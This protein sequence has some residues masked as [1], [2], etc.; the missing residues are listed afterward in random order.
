M[1]YNLSILI[2][3]LSIIAQS[4]VK[5]HVEINLDSLE[6]YSEFKMLDQALKNQ[7]VV[8]TGENHNYRMQNLPF[9]FKF[10]RYLHEQHDFDTYILEFGKGVEWLVQKYIYEDDSIAH[11]VIKRTYYKEQT[12]L[13]ERIKE[14]YDEQKLT[15]P[16]KV[17]GIDIDRNWGS[18]L[19]ALE[20]IPPKEN[21][22]DSLRLVLESV[23]AV[24]DLYYNN[25]DVRFGFDQQNTSM[26]KGFDYYNG[27]NNYTGS[28]IKSIEIL[29]D[30]YEQKIDGFKAFL[31][32]SF[33]AYDRIMKGLRKGLVWTSYET[34]GVVQ[35]KL[36]REQHIYENMMEFMETKPEAKV[37]G[38]FG[39]CHTGGDTLKIDDCYCTSFRSFIQRLEESEEIDL[40][41]KVFAMPILYADVKNYL[42]VSN[43]RNY[44]GAPGAGFKDQEIVKWY[45]SL[46][47]GNSTG[48]Q[49]LELDHLNDTSAGDIY[50]G[51]GDYGVD[52]DFILI[53]F[54]T[55]Y[56]SDVQ[57]SKN[58]PKHKRDYYSYFHFDGA[59]T[60]QETNFKQLN[61]VMS[62][63]GLEEYDPF[64]FGYSA[65]FLGFEGIGVYA[66]IGGTWWKQET[67]SND[68]I[69]LDLSGIN[70]TGQIGGTL[71]D[72]KNFQLA[73]YYTYGWSRLKLVE[74]LVQPVA[75]LNPQS[76]LETAPDQQNKYL[77]P[78]LLIGGG[79]DARVQL[80][81]FSI[82]LKGGYN[83]DISNK[84][85][86]STSG[87]II[88]T[89]HRHYFV[90]AG[91]S[92]YFGEKY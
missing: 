13:F 63:F 14:Y 1:K 17:I 70:I 21:I 9:S 82:F 66:G 44:N 64:V 41:Q 47:A 89:T 22:P 31:G 74:K 92:L 48:F 37:F 34:D 28:K 87:D 43:Y 11:E 58:G 10:F 65:S 20:M 81:P 75:G 2:M 68:S 40:K 57:L 27:N 18:T 32:N 26:I 54:L 56:G 59:Y 46:M 30:Q 77:N 6:D 71:L 25:Y 78:A 50:S 73:L 36:Y 15:N 69:S 60:L 90:S 52:Y 51:R 24:K 39:R 16:F 8:M 85:W 76:I 7:Q 86:K 49:L 23:S 80:F 83:F 38:Q 72:H 53:D 88:K 35:H 61:T 33:D 79:F 12:E 91:V 84:K 19:N 3:L 4:Q 5:Q 45:Q 42:G 67:R 29:V 62:D 55:T